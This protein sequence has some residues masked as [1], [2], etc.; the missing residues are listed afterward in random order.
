MINL[1]ARETKQIILIW[2]EDCVTGTLDDGVPL[3]SVIQT[4]ALVSVQVGALVVDG[5]VVWVQPPPLLDGDLEK[6]V[7]DL[8]G[9]PRMV[10]MPQ[11]SGQ[12]TSLLLSAWSSGHSLPRRSGRDT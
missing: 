10:E 5:V 11:S 2:Y 12:I 7:P 9:V 6:E 8:V 4:A 3:H 1:N